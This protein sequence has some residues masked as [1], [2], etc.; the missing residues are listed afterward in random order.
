[1]AAPRCFLLALCACALFGCGSGEQVSGAPSGEPFTTVDPTINVCPH[2]A[3]SLV[4]PLDI[5]PT[6]AAQ[7]VVRATDPDGNSAGL[8]YDWSASSGTFSKP[9]QPTTTYR[10]SELGPQALH[11]SARDEQG[12]AGILALNV[13]CIDH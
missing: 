10:C 5:A 3:A 4:I 6:V 2:F 9:D 7:I 11:V 13:N 1:M 12:C 8:V